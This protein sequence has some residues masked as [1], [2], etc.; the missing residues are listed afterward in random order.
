MPNN[1]CPKFNPPGCRGGNGCKD[2][3]VCCT[4]APCRRGDMCFKTSCPG[5][6]DSEVPEKC[7]KNKNTTQDSGNKIYNEIVKL[8]ILYSFLTS[9]A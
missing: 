8:E 7:Y 6:G 2:G 5:I 3:E 4:C 1:E 9:I